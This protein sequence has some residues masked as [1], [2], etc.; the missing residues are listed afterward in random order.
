MRD[1]S[2]LEKL[3]PSV[4]NALVAVALSIPLYLWFG[5]GLGWKLSAIL[6]F[7]IMQIIDTHENMN[8]R[9][10]GMRIFG[11][12]WEKEYSRFQRNLYSILYTL[13]FSTIFFYIYFP[14][15]LF[16]ANIVLLQIPSILISH[17]TFHSLVAGGLRTKIKQ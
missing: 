7:Y 2:I 6:I 9:C 4:I 1:T 17:T 13:S 15:D 3:I 8:F 5:F 14:L 12:T 11:S 16:L 10:F